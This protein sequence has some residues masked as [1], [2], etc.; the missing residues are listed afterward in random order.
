MSHLCDLFTRAGLNLNLFKCLEVLFTSYWSVYACGK[1]AIIYTFN[2]CPF[3]VGWFYVI[4]VFCLLYDSRSISISTAFW[5]VSN[6]QFMRLLRVLRYPLE[7]N[8][9]ASDRPILGP[10]AVPTWQLSALTNYVPSFIDSGS[11]I[12]LEIVKHL[13]ITIDEVSTSHSPFCEEISKKAALIQRTAAFLEVIMFFLFPSIIYAKS[14]SRI[15]RLLMI[16]SRTEGIISQGIWSASVRLRK[17]FIQRSFCFHS[18]STWRSLKALFLT[19]QPILIFIPYTYINMAL[20]LI[21]PNLY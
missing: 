9:S 13:R 8:V 2:K 12:G 7:S 6:Q 21:W 5:L 18:P 19:P 15:C 4:L 10:F 11:L 1:K 20:F 14:L 16:S 17:A 3:L